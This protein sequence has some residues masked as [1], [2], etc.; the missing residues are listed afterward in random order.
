MLYALT[1]GVAGYVSALSYKVMGGTNWVRNVL[2]TT[3][4]FCGPLLVVFAFLNTVAIVY[5][6]TAALPFGTI[7]IIF[8]IWALITFPLTVLGGIAG[9]N[10]KARPRRPLDR[11]Q[12]FG[13]QGCGCFIWQVRVTGACLQLCRSAVRL[14]W[15]TL[16]HMLLA[17]LC[18]AR[19][20]SEHI[21]PA[22]MLRRTLWSARWASHSHAC[23]CTIPAV[24]CCFC[25]TCG[26]QRRQ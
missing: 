10:S 16:L 15:G 8:V 6:S 12:G 9:K 25:L 1:A 11:I 21:M 4:L 17:L 5:R 23:P 2:L 19:G 20:R 22:S 26:P 14:S 24:H 18:L 3:A 13:M 7:C